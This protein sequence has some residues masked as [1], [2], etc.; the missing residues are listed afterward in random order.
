M[1]G[2]SCLCGTI[3]SCPAAAT[4][5]ILGLAEWQTPSDGK[6]GHT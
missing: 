4:G 6:E 1:A 2:F 5:I 3:A